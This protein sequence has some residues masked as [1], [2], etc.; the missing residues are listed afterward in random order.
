MSDFSDNFGA[1]P[2]TVCD[3]LPLHCRERLVDLMLVLEGLLINEGVELG[4]PIDAL[5]VRE[6]HFDGLELEGIGNVEDGLDIEAVV[7]F[8]HFGCFMNR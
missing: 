4:L 1:M 2:N 5:N 7:C 3:T 6:D 8:P